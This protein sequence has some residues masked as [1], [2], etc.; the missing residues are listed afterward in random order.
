MLSFN[1]IVLSSRREV[2]PLKMV[3]MLIQVPE[4]LKAKLNALRD[5]GTTASGFIR[6]LLEEHF[7]EVSQIKKGR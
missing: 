6:W 2:V 3:R 7:R 4:S 5:H 1:I